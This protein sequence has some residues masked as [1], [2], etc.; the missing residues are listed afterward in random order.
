MEKIC[1]VKRRKPSG[2]GIVPTDAG[3]DNGDRSPA[4]SIELTPQQA[5]SMRCNENFQQLYSAQSAPIFLNLHFNEGLPQKMLKASEICQVLQISKN[6]LGKLLKAGAVK[7]YKI[8]RLRRFAA[9]DVMEYLAHSFG[10]GKLRTIQVNV[11]QRPL[12]LDASSE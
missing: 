5:E 12:E 4:L 10:L 2:E 7:S 8:G 3:T 1:I 9:E 11:S 6:T